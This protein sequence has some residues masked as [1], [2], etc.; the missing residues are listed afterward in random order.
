[1]KKTKEV[2]WSLAVFVVLSG[3]IAL[4]PRAFAGDSGAEPLVTD[5]PDFTESAETVPQGR[6]QVET[7]VTVERTGEARTRSWDGALLRVATG[8]RSELRIGLPSY[9]R[10]RVASGASSGFDDA[11]LGA[12]FVLLKAEVGK[13]QVAL[14]VGSTLPTGSRRV[15]ERKYQP[16]AVLAAG[17]E[18][19]DKVA[20][21]VNF[22]AV[23]SSSEG[24]RFGQYFG[25]ASLGCELY[26]NLGAFVEAYVFNRTE[27]GGRRQQY[28][29][30]GLTY[31]LNHDLQ[32]DARIGVGL[33]NH[34]SGPDYFYGVGVSQ[35]F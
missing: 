7:G 28:F 2:Q 32:L 13:P 22:G 10:E 4:A 31:L 9:V 18:I 8:H 14:L 20:L 34:V 26:P 11:F 30:T 27:A 21:G 12:K 19:S 29:D 33:A 16:E 3:V 35:R 5:R 15:G 1:M 6:V 23:G 17:I 24:E 25:S